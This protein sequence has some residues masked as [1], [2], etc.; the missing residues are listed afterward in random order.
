MT[1]I[2]MES[3]PRSSPARKAARFLLNS[4]SN[5]NS[6]SNGNGNGNGNR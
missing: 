1:R 6:N 3:A 2:G 4:N 5:S